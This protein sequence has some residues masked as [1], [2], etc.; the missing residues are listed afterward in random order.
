MQDLQQDIAVDR[1]LPRISISASNSVPLH[2]I[3][4]HTAQSHI[5]TKQIRKGQ[6]ILYE[7]LRTKVLISLLPLLLIECRKNRV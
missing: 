7:M 5:R 1:V 4:F 2:S 6:E 3:K